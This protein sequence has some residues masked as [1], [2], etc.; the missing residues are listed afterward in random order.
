[1]GNVDAGPIYTQQAVETVMT[2]FGPLFISIA[3]FFF[4]FT[5]LLA[6]YYIAETTLT[7]LDREVKYSWLK[8]VLKLGFN[9]GL[10]R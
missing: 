8:P 1:M 6:Y 4:A 2:G 3:I 7:Y 5:T 10:Y 9:Y